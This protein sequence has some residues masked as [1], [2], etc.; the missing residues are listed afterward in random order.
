[1]YNIIYIYKHAH[2]QTTLDTVL[3]SFHNSKKKIRY[4]FK[5]ITAT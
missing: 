5:D 1:M 4:C 2:A 3:N